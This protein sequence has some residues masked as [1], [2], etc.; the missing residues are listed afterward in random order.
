MENKTINSIVYD[1]PM[2]GLASAIKIATR[3]Q[4]IYSYNISNASTPGFRPIR[5]EDELEDAETKIENQEFNIE[6]E[7]ARMN[8]NRLQHSALVR[9]LY[10]KAQLM[11][12]VV[13]LGKGG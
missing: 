4:A 1:K 13:T 10:T 2:Q 3:K 5:F 8:E 11:R 9:I 6:E 12:K 7:M